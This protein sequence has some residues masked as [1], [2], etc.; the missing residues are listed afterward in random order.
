ME[1]RNESQPTC[2]DIL[3]VLG[4]NDNNSLQEEVETPERFLVDSETESRR[5]KKKF[6]ME[7]LYK[8]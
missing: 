6:S 1:K 2:F 7:L 8:H 3:V 5:F 4:E